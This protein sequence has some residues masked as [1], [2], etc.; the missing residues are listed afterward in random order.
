MIP[1]SVTIHNLFPP[2][3]IL[4]L[5]SS[6]SRYPLLPPWLQLLFNQT[7]RNLH[8]WHVP[9]S[10][11]PKRCPTLFYRYTC[12]TRPHIALSHSPLSPNHLPLGVLGFRMS[13]IGYEYLSWK[14]PEEITSLARAHMMKRVFPL[15]TLLIE[16]AE[17]NKEYLRVH[18]GNITWLFWYI[19]VCF[20]WRHHSQLWCWW[21]A[22]LYM[23]DW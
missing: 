3:D 20:W 5:S 2:Y 13:N 23:W 10:I 4:K 19:Y 7:M 14:G 16:E 1:R 15:I 6:S 22:W 11:V 9:G 12:V 17:P 8:S 21:S 18:N